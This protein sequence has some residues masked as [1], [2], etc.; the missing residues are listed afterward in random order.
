MN[1]QTDSTRKRRGLA[2]FALTVFSF[3][4]TVIT[5][6]VIGEIYFRIAFDGSVENTREANWYEFDARRGWRLRPGDYLR[7]SFAS[8][9]PVAVSINDWGM[10]DGAVAARIAPGRERVSIVGDSFVFAEALDAA[11]RFTGKLQAL[12]GDTTEIVNIGVPSYGTG[13]QIRLLEDLLAGGYEP[14][15]ALVLIFF[16]NDL[17][18]NLGLDYSTLEQDTSKPR[19]WVDGKR[20]RSVEPQRPRPD[21]GQRKLWQRSLFVNFLKSR[22]EILAMRYPAVFTT[23]DSIGLAPKVPRVPGI[24]A[25]WY[26]E[27][28]EQRWHNT[29]DL[30]DYFADFLARDLAGTAFSIAFIPSPLQTEA[31][32][33]AMISSNLEQDARYREFFDDIDRPQRVLREFAQERKIRF[34]DFTPHL[35]KVEGAYFPSDGH[36]NELGSAIAAGALY[37]HLQAEPDGTR[38]PPAR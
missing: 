33:K 3:L 15:R 2:T 7:F 29:R 21:A 6:A 31:V 11:D 23:L 36:F 38:E 35:R 22:V 27:G 4:V 30:L 37:E 26:G 24:V 10:R 8:H 32:F 28:W 17:Q 16:T 18:D 20:L 12:F 14:G 13:Q 1:K 19:F 5:V 25:G 9:R 34:V